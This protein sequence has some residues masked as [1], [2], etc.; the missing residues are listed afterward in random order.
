MVCYEAATA[1]PGAVSPSQCPPHPGQAPPVHTP[2]TRPAQPERPKQHSLQTEQSNSTRTSVQPPAAVS[3]GA[4]S[5]RAVPAAVPGRARAAPAPARQGHK[6]CM[7]HT[8]VQSQRRKSFT[9]APESATLGPWSL[10]P[11]HAP[12]LSQP[13]RGSACTAIHGCVLQLGSPGLGRHEA[14]PVVHTG[15][16]R[17]RTAPACCVAAKV[18][19]QHDA[20]RLC[21]FAHACDCTAL[22]L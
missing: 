2:A 16:R 22:L 13:M 10:T 14:A 19:D 3:T 11:P 7:C 4:S 9:H 18:C 8:K 17:L 1:A 15:E 21:V 20:L 5:T 12:R 6:P